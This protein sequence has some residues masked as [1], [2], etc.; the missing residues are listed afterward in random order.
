MAGDEVAWSIRDALARRLEE[1][2]RLILRTLA[3]H[4][5]LTTHQITELAFDSTVTARHRMQ[6]LRGLEAVDRFRPRADRGSHP[7]HFLLAPAGAALMAEET[8]EDTRPAI[9]RARRD[10]ALATMPPTKLAHLLGVN[11]IHT[12]LIAHSR[13]HPD[14]EVLRWSTERDLFVLG[15]P[16]D[17]DPYPRPDAI[18][19]WHEGAHRVTA[20]IE[21]DTGTER[22]QR[23]TDKLA[24]Y[25]KLFSPR[26]RHL[27]TLIHV[28][29]DPILLFAFTTPGRETTARTALTRAHPDIS[30]ATGVWKQGISPAGPLWLP[31]NA[32]PPRVRLAQLGAAVPSAPSPIETGATRLPGRARPDAPSVADAWF[33]D[34]ESDPW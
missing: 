26:Q 30:V 2:D 3:T 15:E 5:L 12:A 34:D 19:T 23:L 18:V 22:L 9:R 7:G 4:R 32:R 11:G 21:Y 33:D 17:T 25:T 31:L 24:L 1:R 16:D 20:T 13:A 6:I 8:G 14:T 28:H 10:R 29:D 27:R